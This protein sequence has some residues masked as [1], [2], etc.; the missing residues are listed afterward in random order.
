MAV[1][2]FDLREYIASHGA[3]PRGRGGWA[4]CPS[5]LYHGTYNYLDHIYWA[6]PGTFTEARKA[7]AAHFARKAPVDLV[8]CP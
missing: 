5:T 7:A 1:V 4:F 3:K 6:P 2:T 8:V